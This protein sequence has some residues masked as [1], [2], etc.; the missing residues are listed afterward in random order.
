MGLKY[1]DERI[2]EDLKFIFKTYGNLRKP[3]IV[4]SYKK[5]GTVSLS[6]L[7]RRYKTKDALYELIGENNPRKT[8]YDWCMENN[9]QH[10]LD[11]WDYDLNECSPKDILYSAHKKFYFKCIKC[12]NSQLYF[13]NSFT[14]MNTELHCIYCN[15]F[16]KWCIDN[17][18]QDYLDRWD[19]DKNKK[20]PS[21]ISKGSHTKAWLKC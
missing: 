17:N 1:T 3:S 15:S 8:F 10:L 12:G 16:E 7:D 5:Y 4:D 11:A 6:V 20:L 21:I 2:L 19:Y 18:H 14:N 13:I 9:K